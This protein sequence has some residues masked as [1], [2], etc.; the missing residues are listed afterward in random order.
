MN[1]PA[2]DPLPSSFVPLVLPVAPRDGQPGFGRGRRE[3]TGH[4]CA[5][6]LLTPRG[7]EFLQTLHQHLKQLDTLAEQEQQT[8]VQIQQDHLKLWWVQPEDFKQTH[9]AFVYDT[10]LPDFFEALSESEGDGMGRPF[11]QKEFRQLQQKEGVYRQDRATLALERDGTRNYIVFPD[12]PNKRLGGVWWS[13]LLRA[14]LQW[15]STDQIRN[16]W[17]EIAHRAPRKALELLDRPRIRQALQHTDLT[18]LLDSP[19]QHVRRATMRK[20]GQLARQ[21]KN[22]PAGQ[23]QEKPSDRAVEKGGLREIP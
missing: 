5:V 11:L 21:E 16:T 8:R 4:L 9:D 10:N 1:T 6:V 2:N 13:D 3:D 14:R 7:D 22:S 20:T 15:C 12:I 18:P 23:E 19:H 17:Q